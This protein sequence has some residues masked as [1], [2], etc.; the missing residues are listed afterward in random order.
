MFENIY[1]KARWLDGQY[2]NAYYRGTIRE[3]AK[4]NIEFT[5]TLTFN[6]FE[7]G[8]SSVKAIFID[9]NKNKIEMFLTECE[10]L[11]FML[12]DLRVITGTW[13]FIKRGMNIGVVLVT[14]ATSPYEIL[15]RG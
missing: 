11:M 10:R 8:R 7:R 9:T 14:T 6:G 12:G 2:F 4:E 3:F 13:T 5:E 15:K 1:K